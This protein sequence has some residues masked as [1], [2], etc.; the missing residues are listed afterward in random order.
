[1]TFGVGTSDF[2]CSWG[3][4]GLEYDDKEGGTEMIPFSVSIST[5]VSGLFFSVVKSS[6]RALALGE[7]TKKAG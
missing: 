1:M 5:V 6:R 3:S 2:S 4:R 7:R